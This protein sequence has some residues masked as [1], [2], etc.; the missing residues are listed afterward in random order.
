MANGILYLVATPIGNLGDISTRAREVL[1]TVDLVA[2]ED[3]RRTGGLLAHL[4]IDARMISFFEGNERERVPELLREL[5]GGRSIALVSD[6]GTPGLSDP[7]YRLVRAC[8]EEEIDVRTVPGA[9]AAIA[10]LVISGLPTDRFSFEGFVPRREG[11]RRKRLEE[12]AGDRRTLVFY[13]S[14]KRIAATIQQMRDALG[15]RRAA[16]ARE[17]T[18]VH[19]EVVR[20]SL[21]QI[22]EEIVARGDIKGEIVLVVEGAPPPEA[23]D[24]ATLVAQAEAL[25][26]SGTKKRQAAQEVAREHGTHPNAIY[27]ALIHPRQG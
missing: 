19:E 17:L 3:T 4:M 18:K 9:S 8:A 5:R 23:P 7:G 20:G 12:I 2:C 15:D 27:E 16:L 22:L 10:A 6:A 13:E 14:P 11:E 26:A 1:D 25:V 24:L 21:S